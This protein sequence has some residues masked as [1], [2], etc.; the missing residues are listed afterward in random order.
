MKDAVDYIVSKNYKKF[1]Y[2]SPPLAYQGL[3]NIYTQEERLK[4][5]EQGLRE[6]HIE[7]D[8]LIVSDRK[9][10]DILANIEFNEAE[11]TAIVC[12]CDLYALEVMNHLKAR[13][14]SIPKDVGV[15]GFDDI[16]MLKY[17]SPRLTTVQYPIEEIGEKAVKS[18]IHKIEKDSFLTTPLLDYQ[19]VIGESI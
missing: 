6:N 8:P 5:F 7:K 3:S 14:L 9:Y 17:I 12:S 10:L 16:D 18:M 2:I 13:E 19:I 11:K 4:G 1:I 15:M